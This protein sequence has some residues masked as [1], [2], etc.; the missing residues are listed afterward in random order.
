[1]QQFSI[2]IRP[3]HPDDANEWLRLRCAL[4]PEP[5][6]ETHRDEMNAWLALPDSIV[7]VAARADGGGLAGF[8]EVGTRSVADGCET[9][10]VAYLE[11]WYVDADVRRRGVGGALIRTA[12]N[13]ARKKGFREF[14]SDA[15]LENILSQEAHLA[16]GFTETERAVLYMKTL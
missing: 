16:L 15:E 13:W 3:Y 7:L 5:A 10:P 2:N 11:G 6:I 14:A 4:W 12:E 9:S 1:M 8:A